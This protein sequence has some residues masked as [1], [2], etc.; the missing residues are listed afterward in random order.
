MATPQRFEATIV[1]TPRGGGGHLVEVP[2][3]VIE[4]LGGKGRIPVK[5]TLGGVPYRMRR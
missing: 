2:P 1:G 4:A 3:D 5:A